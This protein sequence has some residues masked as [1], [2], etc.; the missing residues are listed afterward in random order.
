MFRP[1]GGAEVWW[2]DPWG[3]GRLSLVV[4]FCPGA[5]SRPFGKGGAAT[6]CAQIDEVFMSKEVYD[7]LAAHRP[8]Y[9]ATVDADTPRVRPMGFI[10]EHECKIWFGMGTHKNV[11]KQLRANPKVE[12][13]T[14]GGPDS[15]WVRLSGEAVFLAISSRLS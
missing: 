8:F 1:F 7:F 9:M 3:F 11:Y 14:T 12:I 2:L 6:G 5:G 15:D 10:M 13:V 4:Y